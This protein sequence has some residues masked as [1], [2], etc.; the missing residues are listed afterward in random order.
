MQMDI[1]RAARRLMA[2]LDEFAAFTDEPGK[3]TRLY[4]SPVL[5]RRLRALR[6]MGARGRHGAGDRRGRQRPRALRGQ[7]AARAG[8]DDRLAYR[9]RARRRPL[10]R[11]S[12][13]ARGARASS[14]SCAE[15]GERLD[16]A[17]DIVAFGDEE[18]VRFPDHHDR[19]ARARRAR[20]RRARSTRADADG[21]HAARGADR[22]R[23]RSRTR[24]SSC[25]RAASPPSSNCISSRGRCWRPRASRSA[26]SCAINGATR[27]AA[28]VQGLAGHAGAV[29]MRLRQDALAASGRDDPGDR[30]AR[31][32]GA[33]PRR[34]RRAAST[35]SP[36]RSTSFPGWCAF[37]ST[38]ARRATNGA[39]ARSPTSPRRCR[40]SP[41]RRKV[42]LVLAPT[43]EASAYVCDPRIVAG[44][45]AA[46]VG[47]R[48]ASRSICPPAPATTR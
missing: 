30:G 43:H 31:A 14:S 18:G 26:R 5:S 4:L 3:L 15:R 32:R 41:T 16:H 28:T 21:R 29:P 1:S 23:R 27:L 6:A 17:I 34:H 48:P 40:R 39:A 33:G 42:E 36:A 10:R 24:C 22:L 44:F 37:P 11:Q 35:P 2:R 45:D 7:D 47:D 13:R 38:S 9:H 12:R 19:L 25:A 20:V 8:A 46:L